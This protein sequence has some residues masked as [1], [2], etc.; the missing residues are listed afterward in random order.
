MPQW[1]QEVIHFLK[2]PG[3]LQPGYHIL[4]GRM[5]WASVVCGQHR[6]YPAGS[7]APPEPCLLRQ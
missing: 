3:E 7:Y 4:S 5:I 2:P 1:G 6:A